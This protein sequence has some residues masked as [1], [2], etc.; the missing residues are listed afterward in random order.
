MT[1][2]SLFHIILHLDL[3]VGALF[4]DQGLWAY[5]ILMLIIFCETGLVVAPFLPGDSLLF[6]TGMV[7][8]ATGQPFAWAWIL[9][10][11]S[12]FAGD[13]VNY[14][15][16]R[17]FG[18]KLF[19]RFPRV[20]K[21]DYLTVT[22]IFYQRYGCG[23]IVL[24][25][26]VPLCR[27]M[28]PFFGGLSKMSYPIYIFFSIISAC[29]WVSLLLLSSYYLGTIP[30]IKNNFSK[31]ILCVIAISLLPGVISY[32]KTVWKKTPPLP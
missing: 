4:K 29:F 11:L 20:L 1:F 30:L 10:I 6:A 24:A 32:I 21:K 17:C 26:F 19:E 8:A 9:L 7:L 18:R 22:E 25:R 27:T 14:W 12:A 3:Y 2:M 31:V 5:G 16:G 28:V 23:A 15:I 13:N